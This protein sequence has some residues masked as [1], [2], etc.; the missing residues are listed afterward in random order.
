MPRAQC[1]LSYPWS[2]TL[3][4]LLVSLTDT[5]LCISRGFPWTASSTVCV[6]GGNVVPC[7]CLYLYWLTWLSLILSSHLPGSWQKVRHVLIFFAAWIK[8]AFFCHGFILKI[9]WNKINHSKNTTS[10]AYCVKT[11]VSPPVPSRPASALELSRPASAPE[12]SWPTS[13]TH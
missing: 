7:V 12:P 8:R 11:V 1:T 13:M 6:C 3:P 4:A 9:Q 10:L 5:G 2:W